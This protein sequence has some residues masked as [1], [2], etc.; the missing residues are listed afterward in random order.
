MWLKCIP[1]TVPTSSVGANRMGA[2][3]EILFASCEQ[4]D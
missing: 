4:S 1:Y 2:Q 3:A